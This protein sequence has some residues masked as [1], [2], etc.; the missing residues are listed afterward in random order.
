MK[1]TITLILL[2]LGLLANAQ[3]DSPKSPVFWNGYTQ[4]RFTSNLTNVN[5]FAM[6]RM[7]LWVNSTPDFNEHW[8][9]KVQANIT[10]YH[11]EK[12][13]LQDVLAFYKRGQ[14][15]LNMGQFIPHFSLQRFQPDYEI[16]L[17][18]RSEV[19]NALV[20][21]GTLGVRDIGV[22]ASYSAKN[23]H[24]QTWLGAFNGYGIKEYRLNY[25]GILLTQ[26]T[27]FNFFKKRLHAGYSVMYRNVDKIQLS[28][29][30]PDS[31]IHSGN[32]FRYNLF[33]QYKSRKIQVQLEYIRANLGG[34]VARGYYILT[35]LSLGR[36]QLFASWNKYNDLIISTDDSPVIHFGYNYFVN[37]DNLKI[38]FDNGMRMN[39]AKL[40]NY[41]GTIQLQIFFN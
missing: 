37:G 17:T 31:V 18:E 11:N 13:L 26:K 25:S 6:R 28:K 9:F 19:I 7:K 1:R 41:F 32:D 12:F 4:L 29:I 35:E 34:E 22:E 21:N 23:N 36:N 14:F 40:K 38:M 24:I 30:L 39:N 15:R 2:M 8:G 20:P 3:T 5:S 27:A 33:A 10:S 16:P